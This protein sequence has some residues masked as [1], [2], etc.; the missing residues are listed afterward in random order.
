MSDVVLVD[1]RHLDLVVVGSHSDQRVAVFEVTI[2]EVLD[3]EDDVALLILIDIA[4]GHNKHITH[5]VL[6]PGW[7]DGVMEK[8][9]GKS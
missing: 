1:G 6:T 8:A 5:L 2:V 3:V 4:M 9:G 7:S